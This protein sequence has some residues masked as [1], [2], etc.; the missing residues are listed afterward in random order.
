[1]IS[2]QRDGRSAGGDLG[3]GSG[4][5]APSLS[6]RSEKSMQVMMVSTA[7]MSVL[8]WWYDVV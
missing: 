3:I 4:E 1:V 6:P 5:G 8:R 7:M 2:H